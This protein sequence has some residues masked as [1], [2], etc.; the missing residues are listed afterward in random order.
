MPMKITVYNIKGGVGKTD[1]SLN[2]ALTMD[3]AIITNEPFSPI[4]KVF[5]ESRFIK[6]ERDDELPELPA[7]QYDVIFDLGGYLDNRAISALKQSDCVIVP[8]INEFKDVHTTVNFIQEIEEYNKRIII[9]VNK[10]QKGDFENI[11]EIMKKNY[12]RYPVL[13]IKSSRSLPNIMREKKSIKEMVE[14]GGLKAYFYKSVASQFEKLIKTI[15]SIK[16]K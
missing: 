4:E 10:A 3:F 11:K 16:K 7:D 12:P 1:I 5:G 9:V 2:L 13:E 15:N 8:L 14:E 6:L